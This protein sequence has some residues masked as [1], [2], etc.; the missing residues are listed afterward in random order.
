MAKRTEKLRLKNWPQ[1]VKDFA[2]LLSALIAIGGAVICGGKWLLTEANASTNTRIDALE[3][4]I[5]KNYLEEKLSTTRLELMM[6]IANDPEN[7]I[8]IEKLAKEYFNPPLN[9]NKYMTSVVSKWCDDHGI[10]CGTII[11]K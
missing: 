6:L 11:L 3:A 2:A 8:E 9:G 7:V 4:K 1:K 10:N 5:D